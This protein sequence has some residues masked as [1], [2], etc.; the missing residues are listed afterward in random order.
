MI[1]SFLYKIRS[2]LKLVI[3]PHPGSADHDQLLQQLR[4]G[5]DDGGVGGRAHDV[6]AH[7]DAAVGGLRG[8]AHQ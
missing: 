2:H 4:A 8:H 3:F 1:N 7:R 5:Q 6:Q